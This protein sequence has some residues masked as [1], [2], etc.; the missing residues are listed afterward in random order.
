[1]PGRTRILIGMS[2]RL[3]GAIALL[4]LLSGCSAVGRSATYPLAHTP[5]LTDLSDRSWV[6][7]SISDRGIVAGTVIRLTFTGNTVT[8][9]AGCNTLHG[10]ASIDKHEL[11]VGPL[12]ATKVGCDPMLEAQDRWVGSF[13]AARPTIE[14]QSNELWL[15]RRDTVLHLTS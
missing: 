13:L 5:R 8:A 9:S 11:V 1:M 6:A 3:T 15:S 10:E 4:V 12:A 14:R 2:R 7:K